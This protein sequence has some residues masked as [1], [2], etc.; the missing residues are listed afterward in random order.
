MNLRDALSLFVERH[1]ECLPVADAQGR[2]VG[3][4]HFADLLARPA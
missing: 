4:L 2:V 1:V 3:A